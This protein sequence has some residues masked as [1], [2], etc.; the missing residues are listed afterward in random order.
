MYT[1]RF[2]GLFKPVNG[3]KSRSTAGIMCY[4]WLIYKDNH[5]VARGHGAFA[6]N[7]LASSNTAEYLALIEGLEALSDMGIRG[8]PVEVIGDAQSVIDQMIGISTVNS[9]PTRTLYRRARRLVSV[10]RNLSLF[11]QP[12]AYNRDADRLTRHA[13]SQVHGRS[14]A[15]LSTLQS[16]GQRPSRSWQPLIDFRIF[17]NR[18]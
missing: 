18:I 6:H 17:Q 12:R 11:W 8:E 10:F 7:Q 14:S 9:V 2:D 4:G 5:L 16:G 13:M 1:L 15:Y 3:K